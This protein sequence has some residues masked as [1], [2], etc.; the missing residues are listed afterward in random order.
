MLSQVHVQEVKHFVYRNARPLDLCRWQFLFEGGSADSVRK[1]LT[2]YQN[3]DGG[4]GHA[5][6]ADAWNPLST[7]L[8]TSTAVHIL[9][10]TSLLE[11]NHPMIWCMLQYL[12]SG[13]DMQGDR[14]LSVVSTNNN[15]PHAPW[16]EMDSISTSH[17]EFNPTVILAGFGLYFAPAGTA[18]FTRCK[19]I[20]S[21]L[22]AAFLS[23]PDISMHSLLCIESLLGWIKKANLITSFPIEALEK[24]LL[25][26]MSRLILADADKWEGYACRPSEFIHSPQHPLYADFQALIDK[27]LDWLEA[28]RNE[29]GVWDI[30]WSWTGY[31][32]AFAISENWWKTDIA[33]RNMRFLKAFHRLEA[34]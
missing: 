25:A 21:E 26:Q 5:L 15:A 6:E 18:L 29:E 24:E 17:S 1:A 13:A 12:D 27:E 31:E 2:A 33:L 19:K 32:K 28:V 10:E 16:W 14:W 9:W 23:S 4:F 11:K 22:I 34:K 30:T 3:E 20:A 8:Q 7:P